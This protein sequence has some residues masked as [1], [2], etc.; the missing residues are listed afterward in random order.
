MMT[1]KK[2]KMRCL[3]FGVAASL[4]GAQAEAADKE[5]L[6]MLLQNG[7]INQEQYETL[8][9]KEMLT[10]KDV[11]DIKIK[12]DK[13]GLQ[14]E[15]AEGD[16]KFAIGGRL[17]A[18][19]TWHTGD[20]YIKDGNP[21]DKIEANDGTEIRRGRISFKGTMWEDW[22]FQTEV[23]FADNKVGVKDL[24]LTYEGLDWLE[25]TV[26]NQKQPISMELQESSNDI[27]FTE[28]SLL[29]SLTAPLF[30]RAIGLHFK[31]SGDN[32]SAQIG[33]Y[34]DTIT[35]NKQNEFA[36]EGWGVASRVTYAPI[37]ESDH[38]L[39]LGAYGGFRAPNA[40]D[41]VMDS[42]LTFEYETTHMSNLKLTEAEIMNVDD[43]TLGGLEAA[44]MYGPFSVQGEY[45]RA[46][47]QRKDNGMPALNFDAWYIQTAWT[48][49]GESRSY[50]GSDG[51]F[52]RL[53]P[54]KNFSLRDGGGWG[55]WEV[56][57]RFDKNDLNDNDI[58]GGSESALTVALNWYLN[59]NVRFMAD[60]RRTIDV[61]GS[62]I[63]TESGKQPEDLDMF[64][65]RAQWAF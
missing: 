46:W 65:L 29:N 57:A 41:E 49:T 22:N 37:M 60:Y 35:A 27:M 62:R 30:D 5:L 14:F 12:L 28:R 43:V 47:V 34:G 45:A 13:K 19:A 21:M 50:K 64:T 33:A 17:H 54:S 2:H 6:D 32:W 8:I 24:F 61:T 53:K 15:T 31:S 9:E 25:I 4:T 10:K 20:Q 38:V 52:K 7:A 11:D 44:Y 18:D 48:L 16:F 55:A 59:E 39:H 1:F 26:G 40:N 56:A 23:D 51:E 58:M 36:D 63:T 3:A 42:T